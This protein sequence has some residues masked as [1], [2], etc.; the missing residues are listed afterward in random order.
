MRMTT[1]CYLED[2][3]RYLMLHRVRKDASVDD[4]H[5][6]WI[7][8][9][10]KFEADES[11]EDCMLREVFEE[12]G[13][14]VTQWKYHGLVTFVSD[15]AQSDYMHLFS[16]SK[17]EGELHV[18]DEGDLQWIPVNELGRLRLWEGDRVFLYLMQQQFPF[19]S[20]KLTYRGDE[21]TQAVLN[22]HEIDPD[23]YK[24]Q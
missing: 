5:G 2:E 9:G 23:E 12:T 15:V 21:L 8:V 16:A 14:K 20:L 3:G 19:F 4:S 6:K 17:W 13:L 1:L 7:G 22:G 11:P 18:C 24:I 10:G